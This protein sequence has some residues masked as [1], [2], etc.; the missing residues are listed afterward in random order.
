[1]YDT[2]VS[3]C[4]WLVMNRPA[5]M[6]MMPIVPWGVR[7]YWRNAAL[8]QRP[9]VWIVESWIP[10]VATVVAAP[11]RKLW[12]AYW[13]CCKPS[14]FSMSRICVTNLCFDKALRDE[15]VINGPKESPHLDVLQGGCNWAEG[16]VHSTDNN[17]W[18]RPKLIA[19]GYFKVKLH[20]FGIG[21]AVYRYI[22]LS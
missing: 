14:E 5:V 9:S 8:C 10:T 6:I 13:S 16:W 20:H 4:D 12:P 2:R 19:L 15:F 1:M 21:V 17:I 22:S 18:T 7:M 11:I 3:S